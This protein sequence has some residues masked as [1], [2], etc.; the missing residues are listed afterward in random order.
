MPDALLEKK[1]LFCSLKS[2]VP[3]STTDVDVVCISAMYYIL[4]YFFWVLTSVLITEQR[5]HQHE[6]W[7]EG[8]V[9]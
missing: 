5:F 6:L 7:G 9:I 3:T 1:M 4:Y 2:T 8:G